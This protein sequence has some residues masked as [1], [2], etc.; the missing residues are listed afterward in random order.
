MPATSGRTV[1]GEVCLWIGSYDHWLEGYTLPC[2]GGL[3][4]GSIHGVIGFPVKQGGQEQHCQGANVPEYDAISFHAGLCH[5]SPGDL[6]IHI[7]V[8]QQRATGHSFRAALLISLH[9]LKT[10]RGLWLPV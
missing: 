5:L 10:T 9:S 3:P 6:K 8:R 7:M 1:G 2:Q 4:R